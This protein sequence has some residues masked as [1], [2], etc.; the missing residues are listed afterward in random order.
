VKE[1]PGKIRGGERNYFLSL[2]A[3]KSRY[4]PHNIPVQGAAKRT[5]PAPFAKIYLKFFFTQRLVYEVLK[6]NCSIAL[7]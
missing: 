7:W 1:N 6:V 5:V 4:I 3:K 2:L